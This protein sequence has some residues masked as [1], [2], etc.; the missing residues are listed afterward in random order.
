MNVHPAS[1]SSRER[2]AARL[3]VG[4]LIP[5]VLLGLAIV[6]NVVRWDRLP[7]TLAT[8]FDVS[9]HPDGSMS[10]GANLATTVAVTAL[11]AVV[12]VVVALRRRAGRGDV[13][14]AAM[15]TLLGGVIATAGVSIVAANTD[16]AD[17]RAVTGPSWWLVAVVVGASLAAGSLA[18]WA[19]SR[20]A[21]A[22]ALPAPVPP[23]ALPVEAR[24]SCI[25]QVVSRGW[26]L[27]SGVLGAAGLLLVAVG[28][29]RWVGLGLLGGALLASTFAMLT[30]IA[31]ERGLRV[32]YGPAR[33][34]R[35]RIPLT[36]I[37]QASAI[38]VHPMAWGGWGYRGSL[39]LMR[40]A[41][42]V[43]HSGPGL[44]LDLRDGKV[45]VVT[46]DDPHTAAA[47]LNRG[48]AERQPA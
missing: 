6:P 37:A 13:A 34:P 48:V 46:V 47:V 18:A 14:A 16:A 43:L 8:H 5:L 32:L 45:F 40:Q 23:L 9:R 31:D 42:V 30:V 35:Q 3:L 15:A 26:M 1:H 44:R 28:P 7:S 29:Q 17:W 36:R 19:V 20:Y 4:A 2:R 12:L 33:L 11:C 10:R 41:A 39:R 38:D 27:A 22:A 24:A 25:Q 21:V